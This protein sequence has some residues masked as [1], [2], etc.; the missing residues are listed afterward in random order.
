[1]IAARPASRYRDF[2]ALHASL[3]R[4][5]AAAV[6]KLPRLP[7]RRYG[8]GC[9]SAPE[10]VSRSLW[11]SAHPSLPAAVGRKLSD[12]FASQRQAALQ[13]W[14]RGVLAMPEHWCAELAA[15]L[16]VP[17]LAD[18]VVAKTFNPNTNS[19]VRKRAIICLLSF[20]RRNR[21]IYNQEQWA[22]GFKFLLHQKHKGILM[23][24]CSLLTG[25]ITIMGREGL[26][27]LVPLIINALQTIDSNSEDYY[28][29]KT[30]CP[31]LQVKLLKLLQDHF[32]T[33]IAAVDRFAC[34]FDGCP[35]H[36]GTQAH[37]RWKLTFALNIGVRTA[38]L[39]RKYQPLVGSH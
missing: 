38:I 8:T 18:I 22:Y 9:R 6:S 4:R 33:C 28:Y 14:V 2:E 29:Y 15:F 24:T 1:M 20:F 7:G 19:Y 37:T 32:C 36:G 11:R 5:P 21:S 39:F 30:P 26:Y 35:Q 31:W 12:A 17:E 16:G 27:D 25:V 3:L 34:V 23:S 10:R 13:E